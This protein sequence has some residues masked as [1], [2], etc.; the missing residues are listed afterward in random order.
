MKSLKDISEETRPPDPV[1]SVSTLE[2][3]PIKTEIKFCESGRESTFVQSCVY[4]VTVDVSVF[5]P[6]VSNFSFPDG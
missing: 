6:V 1:A 4:E 5:V 3:S 2:S